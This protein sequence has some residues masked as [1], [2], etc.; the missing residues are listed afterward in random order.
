[1][2]KQ[3]KFFNDTRDF[4][5]FIVIYLE[6]DDK[7]YGYVHLDIKKKVAIVHNKM[8]SWTPR[9]L[10]EA[11]K[12][13]GMICKWVKKRGVEVIKASI[14][15]KDNKW[16]RYTKLFGMSNYKNIGGVQSCQKML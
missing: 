8:V 13:W 14:E 16:L 2:I 10:K 9:V 4:D 7:V 11:V 12:D 6:Y 3:V 1:M 15:D 5:Y